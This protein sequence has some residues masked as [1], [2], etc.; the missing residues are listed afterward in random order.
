MPKA[1]TL[2]TNL[3]KA[4][5][6]PEEKMIREHEEWERQ[7]TASIEESLRVLKEAVK[8]PQKRAIMK[9]YF[10]ERDAASKNRSSNGGSNG[11]TDA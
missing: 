11:G 4:V 8:D 3:V 9:A 6:C 10:E 5:L 1:H 2:L 7:H